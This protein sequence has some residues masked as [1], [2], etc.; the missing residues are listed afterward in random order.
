MTK[1]EGS[2]GLSEEHALDRVQHADAHALQHRHETIRDPELLQYI[3]HVE[4]D[5]MFRDSQNIGNLAVAFRYRQIAHDLRFLLGENHLRA[6]HFRTPV[7]QRAERH[8]ELLANDVHQPQPIFNVFFRRI[9]PFR[10]AGGADPGEL[11]H[12]PAQ[13]DRRAVLEG[14]P[15]APD[16]DRAA[17]S[18]PDP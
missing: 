10:R 4:I 6:F 2:A 9:A 15:R 13:A 7:V 1:T 17:A 3:A 8:I 14:P 18:A 11:A 16:R 12:H 5:G